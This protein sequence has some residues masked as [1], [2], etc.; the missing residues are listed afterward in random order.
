MKDILVRLKLI[1]T[2]TITLQISKDDFVGRLSEIT[3]KESTGTMSDMFDIFSSSNNE[4]K[5]EVTYERFTIK[6]KRR[7]FDTNMNLAI[8]EGTFNVHNGQLTIETEING[9]KY[10]YLLFC[11]LL[12]V[13]YSIFFIG[14]LNSDDNITLIVIPIVLLHGALMFA[15]PYLLMK[16]SVQ[17]LKY[18]L[19]REFFFLTKPR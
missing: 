16:R 1:D 7:F 15:I 8:A 10:F 14:I 9:F 3:D 2:M 6:R 12:V 19:E 17:R 5:G 11:A 4:Y 18:D 13:F